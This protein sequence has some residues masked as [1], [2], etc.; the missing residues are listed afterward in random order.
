MARHV[1]TM[2][3]VIQHIYTKSSVRPYGPAD[4]RALDVWSRLERDVTELH[5]ICIVSGLARAP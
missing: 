3:L 4:S 1:A 2:A 5:S